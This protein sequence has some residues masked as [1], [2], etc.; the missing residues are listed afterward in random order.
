MQ[1]SLDLAQSMYNKCWDLSQSDLGISFYGPCML[2]QIAYNFL[3]KEN[4]SAA[5]NI[6]T[7]GLSVTKHKII[8]VHIKNTLALVFLKQG[9]SYDA[10]PLAVNSL[11]EGIDLMGKDSWKVIEFKSTLAHIYSSIGNYE[12]AESIYLECYEKSKDCFGEK[13]PHTVTYLN[14][15]AQFYLERRNYKNT[16]PLYIKVREQFVSS[17]GADHP[18][19]LDI[20]LFL[21]GLYSSVDRN[22]EAISEL[23]CYLAFASRVLGEENEAIITAATV[24]AN[25]YTKQRKYE[26]AEKTRKAQFTLS[27]CYFNRG[28][29]SKCFALYGISMSQIFFYL[30]YLL[31]IIIAKGAVDAISKGVPLLNVFLAVG[32]VALG[33]YVNV[34]ILS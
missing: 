13:H 14:N 33:F 9:K 26:E 2:Y 23:T 4:F 19:S 7:R 6:L 3:L 18:H 28:L 5:E 20:M 21:A 34:V 17:M 16:L 24:L 11:N 27:I 29:L 15:L 1:G 25:L 32:S 30:W 22:D 12:A 31:A 8:D 10:L